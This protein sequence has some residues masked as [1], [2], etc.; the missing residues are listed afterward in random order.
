MAAPS[1]RRSLRSRRALVLSAAVVAAGVGAG[2]VV[3]NANAGTVDLYHQTLAAK[4]GW[5]SSGTGTTGGAKADAAHTFTVSTRAQLVKALG[6]ATDTTPRIIK[7]SGTIDANTDDSGKKLTCAD[8]AAGTGYSLSAYLKA[9]DPATYGRSKLPS[10]TQ[11][12]ARAAAQKK[13]ALNVTFKVPA[14]TTIVGVPGTAA[15][16][17]GG[18][19][20]VQNVDN[21]IVRNLAFAATEDCFPQWDPT[22]GDDGNWNSN[23]DSV[24]LRGA[25]HVWADHNTFTDGPHFDSANPKYFGRE[26]Q[27]HDGSLDITKGSDLVTVSR[28]QFTNHDKTMLIGSSDTDSVGKLRVSIHHNVWK[29]IVQRAPLA[30]IGQIHIYNNYYDV[31]TLN[32]YAPQYSINSRAKAQVVAENNYWKLPSGAKAAKLLSG[33]GTGSVKGSGN[34]VNGTVT[35]LVA[36]YNAASSKD[37]KT[38]VNWTPTL[39]TGLETSAANLPTSL[40]TTTGSGVLK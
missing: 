40:A 19:L 34:L 37:L 39:T 21:V 1:H 16:I 3:M 5:A 14:N 17:T 29:G 22:D 26:Y 13:Q 8:Y 24:T 30:R 27:I 31:T 4:D 35:D 10:G 32:G 18:M 7:V 6:S 36:A 38:T 20:Q 9:Y 25:T 2:V 33:D 28:N 23:Y 15:G 11:E 12:S